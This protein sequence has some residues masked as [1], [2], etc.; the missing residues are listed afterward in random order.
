MIAV[1]TS[2][3]LAV[4]L[5]EP[6]GEVCGAIL[7]E[8]P[9]VLIS[10]ATLA[11]ALVVAKG[12]SVEPNLRIVLDAAGPTVLPVTAAVAER[13]A[14]AYARWGRG[15]HEAALNWGDCFAYVVAK[16]HDCPL[17]SVGSDFEKTDIQS[18]LNG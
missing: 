4:V 1:D 7:A 14:A 16:D 8:A 10:A 11:E 6:E 12:R 2:A 15:F 17:L 18:V 3:L 5:R 13:V 9:E